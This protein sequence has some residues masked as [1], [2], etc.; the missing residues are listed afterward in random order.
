[1]PFTHITRLRL[2]PGC[3]KITIV[4]CGKKLFDR[5]GGYDSLILLFTL[6]NG[7]F[8]ITFV[9][10]EILTIESKLYILNKENITR[11]TLGH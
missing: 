9:L 3:H 2:V 10:Y 7:S 8:V 11:E 6:G 5:P 4:S 1:M